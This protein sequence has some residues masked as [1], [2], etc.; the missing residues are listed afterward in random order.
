MAEYNWGTAQLFKWYTYDGTPAEGVLY[1]PE[2]FSPDK[3]YPMISYFYETYTEPLYPLRHGAF[4]ELDKLPFLCEQRLCGVCAR[5]Q[6]H[7]PEC[8]ENA[9]IILYA[10]EWKSSAKISQ[11]RQRAAW[12]RRPELGW[13]P[14]RLS[15]DPHRHVCVRRLGCARVEHDI[16]LWWYPLGHRRLPPGAV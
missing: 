13:I 15:C 5:H 4:M 6:I 10:P 16:R 8:R 12:Y 1:L 14:D 2:D 11:H 9:P 3:E 7:T